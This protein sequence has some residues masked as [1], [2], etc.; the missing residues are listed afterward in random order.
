M[1]KTCTFAAV[2]LAA[3]M[4]TRMGRPKQLL[5][6]AG[7]SMLEHAI[8]AVKDAGIVSPVLVLGAYAP[9][10]LRCVKL[11]EK[12]EVILNKDFAEGQASSLRVGVDA[13]SGKCEAA[14]FMLADQPLVDAAL[15]SELMDHF[16]YNN[17]DVL[18]PVYKGQRGNPVIISASLFPRLMSTTG[19]RGARFIFADKSLNILAH[20]VEDK[21]VITDVDTWNAYD[22]VV[23]IIN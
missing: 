6:L 17:P 12:C 14:V 16:S 5:K 7:M 20:E 13:V 11:V 10:I 3:G 9:D 23:R 15:V 2:I 22:Q 19:D 4:S 21:A 8:A 1:N 18:Y